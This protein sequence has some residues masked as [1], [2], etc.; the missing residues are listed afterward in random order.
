M[1]KKRSVANIRVNNKQKYLA[2]FDGEKDYLLAVSEALG[3]SL[4]NAARIMYQELAP[5]FLRHPEMWENSADGRVR[6]STLFNITKAELT[7]MAGQFKKSG[8]FKLEPRPA[9][10]TRPNIQIRTKNRFITATAPAISNSLS[11]SV[12]GLFKAIFIDFV[13]RNGLFSLEHSEINN[14]QTL[15]PTIA[16]WRPYRLPNRHHFAVFSDDNTIVPRF[17]LLADKTGDGVRIDI[18]FK[19]FEYDIIQPSLPFMAWYF[20]RSMEEFLR[21]LYLLFLERHGLLA[22]D[23]RLHNDYLKIIKSIPSW[24]LRELPLAN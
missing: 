19:K 3:T 2:L 18:R 10:L 17:R 20:D 1:K 21:L 22:D 7:E 14:L 15:V 12:G 4:E 8:Y 16:E 13:L 23:F 5:M 9:K 6:S 11:T 24:D